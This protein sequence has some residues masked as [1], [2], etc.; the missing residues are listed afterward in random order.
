MMTMTIVTHKSPDLDSCTAIWLLKRFVY[1]E[2]HFNYV[3]VDVGE[4]IENNVNTIHVDTGGIDYDHH[5]SNEMISAAS[6]VYTKNGLDDEALKKIVDY[7]VLVDHGKTI[8][9]DNHF[10]NLSMAFTGLIDHDSEEIVKAVL[11]ILDG[12]YNSIVLDIKALENFESGIK[13][14]SIYG[15]GMG[16]ETENPKLR[17]L[18]YEHGYDIFLFKDSNTGFSG[19]KADGNSFI[20]FTSLYNEIKRIEQEA[21]WFLHSSKQLLLCGS[22]KAPLKK[23]SKITLKQLVNIIQNHAKK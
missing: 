1:P 9:S 3:F 22:A 21:D 8:I 20:D 2:T 5:D 19:F 13:F 11:V 6:L 7:T 12:I 14:K 18:V 10:M 4:R 17:K 15:T 16:F 23:L